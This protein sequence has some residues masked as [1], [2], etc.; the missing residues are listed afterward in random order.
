MGIVAAVAL[1]VLLDR[2]T[3]QDAERQLQRLKP[4]G[5]PPRRPPGP[6]VR[7]EALSQRYSPAPTRAAQQLRIESRIAVMPAVVSEP[8]KMP[9][10]RR[11]TVTVEIRPRPDQA[12]RGTRE[13]APLPAFTIDAELWERLISSMPGHELLTAGDEG[14]QPEPLGAVKVNYEVIENTFESNWPTGVIP[15]SALEKLLDKEEAFT[16]LLISIGVNEGD[17]TIWDSQELMHSIGEYLGELLRPNDFC[18]RTDYDEFILACPGETGAPAQRHVSHISER[19]WDFQLRGIGAGSILFSWGA[20]QVQDQPL[21]EAIASA[22][23]RMR[24]TKRLSTRSTLT[25]AHHTTV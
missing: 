23:D 17:R 22:V 18:C 6:V 3:K 14:A 19:L 15:Q 25:R 13:S 8:P 24:Q 7:F 12:S 20:V 1:F 11:E 5:A 21:A 10:P 16:G 2:Q 4:R 9:A